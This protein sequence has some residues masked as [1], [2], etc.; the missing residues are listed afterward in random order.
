MGTPITLPETRRLKQAW[1]NAPL[2]IGAKDAS[3]L[4]NPIEN[5]SRSYGVDLIS[6][7][8]DQLVSEGDVFE[9]AGLELEVF[10]T[11]GHSI[12]HVVF[13]WKTG[14]PW[15][16]FGG[17]VLFQGSIGR[18]DFPDGSFEQ[19]AA[20][21]R[22]K[23]YTLPDD[24]LVLPGHGPTTTIG[25][26]KQHNP[27]VPVFSDSPK[28]DVASGT[29]S[30]GTSAVAFNQAACRSKKALEECYWKIPHFEDTLPE[31]FAGRDLPAY[32]IDVERTRS[33]S[34]RGTRVERI[35]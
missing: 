2:V 21:I 4:T 26:E 5:L 7:A 16:V 3:K 23:L 8:A 13:V 12:G 19:L 30:S 25:F 24:T 1:P 9:G 34:L 17:D 11:P 31:R 27:F 18:T 35:R 20:A 15:I 32:V 14:T 22:N 6:P 33:T 10:E 29:A 28:R